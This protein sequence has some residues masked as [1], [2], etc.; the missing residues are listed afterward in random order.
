MAVL[1]DH[2]TELLGELG[3]LEASKLRAEVINDGARAP[4]DVL[5]TCWKA[6]FDTQHTPSDSQSLVYSYKPNAQSC[7]AGVPQKC[8]R[9]QVF[10]ELLVYL[11]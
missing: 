6:N 4:Y 8:H 9:P 11:L 10:A 1:P 3:T 7:L 2:P 5:T